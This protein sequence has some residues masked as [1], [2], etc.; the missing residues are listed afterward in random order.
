MNFVSAEV[1]T[2]CFG[3][4]ADTYYCV[5]TWTGPGGRVETW[6]MECTPDACNVLGP[7]AKPPGIDQLIQNAINE[8]TQTNT[9]DPKFPRGD[10]LP[11]EDEPTINDPQT[12]TEPNI[13]EPGKIEM[14]NLK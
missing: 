6:V 8:E 13:K 9:N 7:K 3:R 2:E 4:S 5:I 11:D 1:T 12:T 10:I 14:P